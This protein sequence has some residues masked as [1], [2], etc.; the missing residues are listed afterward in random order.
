MV[1]AC[2]TAPRSPTK[3]PMKALSLSGSMAMSTL[4][5]RRRKAATGRAAGRT[6][7]RSVR[8]ADFIKIDE[9]LDRE[10]DPAKLAACGS[11]TPE[12]PAAQLRRRHR[13]QRRR[14]G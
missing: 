4:L 5:R 3:R 14:P 1:A 8:D 10:S 9:E 6:I 12:A 11:G 2:I 13:L 7:L